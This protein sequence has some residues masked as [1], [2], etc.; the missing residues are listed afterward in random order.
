MVVLLVIWEGAASF[1]L[2]FRIPQMF[3]EEIALDILEIEVLD[4]IGAE[5]A[6]RRALFAAFLEV[7]VRKHR[8]KF[9]HFILIHL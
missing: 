6:K 5:R 2:V 1:A 4:I 8:H 7:E 3:V 9:L